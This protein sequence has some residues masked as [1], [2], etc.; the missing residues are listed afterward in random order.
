MLDKIAI[1]LP[2][3]CGNTNRSKRV[4]NFLQSWEEQ[5]EGLSDI[6]IALDRDD[7]HNYIGLLSDERISG[8]IIVDEYISLMDK[9]NRLTMPIVDLYK[10][11]QFIGD[12]I[13]LKTKWESEFISYLS[14]VKVGMT[15][16]DDM[17][18]GINLATHP[19]LT[20]NLIKTIGFFGCPAV[21]HC[22]FDNYW[23]DIMLRIGNIKYFDNIKMEHFHPCVDKYEKDELFNMVE[24]FFE[25]D[26]KN[27]YSYMEKNMM[28]DL[29]KI[30]KLIFTQSLP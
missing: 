30:N 12:D 1:I 20:S 19:C 11:V 2:L 29:E 4:Y 15:Y 8:Y 5:T 18:N 23:H 25:E 10:Y 16:G 9:I 26:T 3:R 13:V 6:F 7:Y 24:G 28:K 21:K 14:S 22:Y 17:I 27:Y